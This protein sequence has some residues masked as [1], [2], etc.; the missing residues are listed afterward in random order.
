[1]KVFDWQENESEPEPIIINFENLDHYY[2]STHEYFEAK[3]DF[4]TYYLEN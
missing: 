3:K 1:M 2:T 4:L